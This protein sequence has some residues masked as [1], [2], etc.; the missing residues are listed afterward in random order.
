MFS[1]Q[2]WHKTVFQFVY[3]YF[4]LIFALKIRLRVMRKCD[5]MRKKDVTSLTDSTK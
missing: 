2:K 1:G 3:F 4:I 5:E